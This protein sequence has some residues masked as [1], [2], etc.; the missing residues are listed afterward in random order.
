MFG[1]KK[2]AAL[3]IRLALMCV[4]TF[5]LCSQA[6]ASELSNLDVMLRQLNALEDTAHRSAQIASAPGQRY[7]FDYQRLTDDIAR[8][9]Q[10]LKNHLSPSR[11]HTPPPRR[12]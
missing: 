11:A 12:Y 3:R 2:T 1:S 5:A 6:M 9:R 7:T 4:M 8:I 10:G